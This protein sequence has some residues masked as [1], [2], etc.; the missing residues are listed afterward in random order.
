M[1]GNSDITSFHVSFEYGQSKNRCSTDSWLQVHMGQ[2]FVV[3][4]PIWSSLSIVG[5]LLS[6]M[7]HMV[8]AN[9]GIASLYQTI[10]RHCAFGDRDRVCS[11]ADLIV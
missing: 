8:K 6:T 5:S 11:H 2:M 9:R 7:S 3:V 10:F 4:I 1:V